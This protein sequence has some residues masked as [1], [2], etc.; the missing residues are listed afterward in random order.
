MKIRAR[1]DLMAGQ[2]LSVQIAI[3]DG[4]P[5]VV[6][7]NNLLFNLEAALASYEVIEA[8]VEGARRPVAVRVSVWRTPLT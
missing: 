2:T 1:S 6:L 8:T 4:A 7:A 5:H 3:R